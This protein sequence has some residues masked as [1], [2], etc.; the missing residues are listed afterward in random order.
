MWT[1]GPKVH[2]SVIWGGGAWADACPN[3]PEGAAYSDEA[4]PDSTIEPARVQELLHLNGH[5]RARSVDVSF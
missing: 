2:P 5:K 4:E 1:L 3:K